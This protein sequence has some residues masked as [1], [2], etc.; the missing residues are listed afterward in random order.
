MRTNNTLQKLLIPKSQILDIYSRSGAYKQICP[1]C[2]NAYVG[3]T[4][5]CFTKEVKEH[6]NAFRSNRNTSNYAKHALEYAH[7]FDPNHETVQIL[8]YQGTGTHL[9]TIERY[10][11]YK[12]FQITSI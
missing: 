4:G 2:N 9:I 8:Q 10:F 1:D 6:K 11:I 3:Q 12:D 7:P 5:Q